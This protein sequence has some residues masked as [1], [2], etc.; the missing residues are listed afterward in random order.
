MKEVKQAVK[1]FKKSKRNGGEADTN[2]LLLVIL[3]ILLPPLAVYLHEGEINTKF[4]ISLLLTIL[5]WIPGV[6][7]A[8][9]VILGNG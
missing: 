2:T 8:L 4:W 9:I 1:D 3:A 6:I 5:F 7:Y